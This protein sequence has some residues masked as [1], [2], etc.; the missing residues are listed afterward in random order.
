MDLVIPIYKFDFLQKKDIYNFLSASKQNLKFL[1][2]SKYLNY[3][4]INIIKFNNI[5][6]FNNLMNFID[7]SV[8]TNK[9]KIKNKYNIEIETTFIHEIINLNRIE[10]LNII[11][12]KFGFIGENY[13]NII[14]NNFHYLTFNIKN[15]F[16][17]LN[18]LVNKNYDVLKNNEDQF[19]NSNYY[20]T[21]WS[22]NNNKIINTNLLPLH[23]ISYLND[24]NLIKKY[25]EFIIN[26]NL[27]TINDIDNQK[28]TCFLF[29]I[30][31]QNY[32]YCK[33]LIENNCNIYYSDTN[34]CN[35]FHFL[36]N[37]EN[38]YDNNKFFN[39]IWNLVKFEKNIKNL[40]YEKNINNIAP[41]NY[42]L[43][44]G[45]YSAFKK[46][47]DFNLVK[48][49]NSYIEIVQNGYKY[50]FSNIYK[51]KNVEK[52]Y[53]FSEYLKL[54]K[55]L[56]INNLDFKLTNNLYQKKNDPLYNVYKH[57]Y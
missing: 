25:Y 46:L 42:I 16:N 54:I 23:I 9:I 47:Y 6:K 40:I 19:N 32:D 7:E 13:Y 34:K 56:L 3:A 48:C 49:N 17:L 41:I 53:Q 28:L 36:L 31:L 15:K 55:L 35:L 21:Y 2:N 57:I 5:A 27:Q 1:K 29:S 20:F 14:F 50:Y 37:T 52:T 22:Y 39:K 45:K 8:F 51:S 44:Y 26:N 18:Y 38:C 10:L 11:Y 24:I 43:K 33:F 30:K 12:N 4:I